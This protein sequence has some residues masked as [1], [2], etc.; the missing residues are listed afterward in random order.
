MELIGVVVKAFALPHSTQS[1]NAI[2]P[3]IRAD[4]FNKSVNVAA[5]IATLP[6]RE[7]GGVGGE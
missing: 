3:H 4:F 6:H 2:L 5:Q 1:A 7:A